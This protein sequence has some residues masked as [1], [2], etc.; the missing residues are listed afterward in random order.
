MLPHDLPDWTVAYQQARR[1]TQAGVFEEIVHDL[2]VIQKSCLRMLTPHVKV[3]EVY[4]MAASAKLRTLAT[5][6]VVG[7]TAW[8]HSTGRHRVCS[9]FRKTFHR[10]DN[11]LTGTIGS[12]LCRA[13]R[14]ES[15][16]LRLLVEPAVASTYYNRLCVSE[17]SSELS[18]C[19]GVCG[20]LWREDSL[21]M[22]CQPFQLRFASAGSAPIGAEK[23]GIF[24]TS[25]MAY[26]V[27][28]GSVQIAVSLVS[29]L[30]RP[31]RNS[32]PVHRL[33]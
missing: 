12:Y 5:S 11:M 24:T 9:V 1:W 23:F 16:P 22:Q 14:S 33:G 31:M 25:R 2:R 32:N 15:L 21:R 8:R 18:V 10:R 29:S 4:S 20:V 7:K 28:H 27:A 26:G 13:A 30:L 19:G 6:F 17:R 3:S